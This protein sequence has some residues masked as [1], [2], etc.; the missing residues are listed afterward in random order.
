MKEVSLSFFLKSAADL[1]HVAGNVSVIL[2]LVTLGFTDNMS[3]K[4]LH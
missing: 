1:V 4:L 3:R 2:V